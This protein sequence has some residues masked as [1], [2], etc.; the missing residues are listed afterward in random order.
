M[1]PNGI[2][3]KSSGLEVNFAPRQSYCYDYAKIATTNYRHVAQRYAG[4]Y[5]P[6]PKTIIFTNAD[7]VLVW[8]CERDDSPLDIIILF[9]VPISSLAHRNIP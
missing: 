1:A 8:N 6:V 9:R 5:T 4:H 2:M 3:F 7:G